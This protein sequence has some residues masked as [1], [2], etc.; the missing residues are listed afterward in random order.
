MSEFEELL[1]FD[2]AM[3]MA[4]L[5]REM[6]DIA[7]S[8]G[9]CED[10]GEWY[11][12]CICEEGEIVNLNEVL[13]RVETGTSGT[14]E[15]EWLRDTLQINSKHPD[16]PIAFGRH[17][18]DEVV[19]ARDWAS[20]W[21]RAAKGWRANALSYGEGL[22]EARAWAIRLMQSAKQYHAVWVDQLKL[23]DL[24]DAEAKKWRSLADKLQAE[25]KARDERCC[26]TC[27]SFH[28][29]TYDCR[30]EPMPLSCVMNGY[31]GWEARD[32]DTKAKV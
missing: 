19:E 28:A 22:D 4:K 26:G 12:E 29:G 6:L 15:A 32:V 5:N 7:L 25:L 31:D 30:T 9:R 11:D 13:H 24:S 20:L 18:L 17:A 16:W 21:K 2:D 1:A 8:G 14:E 23:T 10:C 27:R 3:L